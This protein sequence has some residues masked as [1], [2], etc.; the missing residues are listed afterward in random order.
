MCGI[1]GFFNNSLVNNEKIYI[2]SMSESLKHRGPDDF[3]FYKDVMITMG[4]NRFS[5]TDIPNGRQPFKSRNG[6]VI[7]FFNGE[8]YNHADLR[9][10]LRAKGYIF[11]T[12]CDGEVIPHLY[13]EYGYDFLEYLD[14]MFSICLW[15]QHKKELVLAVDPFGIKQLYFYHQDNEFSFSSEIKGLAT[16]P[17]V[18]LEIDTQALY[19]YLYYKAIFPPKTFFKQINKLEPSNFLVIRPDSVQKRQYNSKVGK[20]I[21]EYPDD[22]LQLIEI[23]EEKIIKNTVMMVPDEVNFGCLLS[24]GLDSSIITSI[25]SKYTDRKFDV[26]S[27]GYPGNLVADEREYGRRLTKDLGINLHEVILSPNEI[28]TLL[29]SVNESIE[30]PIQDPITLPTYK[31]IQQASFSNKVLFTGDGSDELFGGYAR[32]KS[33]IKD[34]KKEY[35]NQLG[36]CNFNEFNQIF[37]LENIP[38]NSFYNKFVE[39]DSL[40]QLMDLEQKT[41]LPGYHLLRLDKLSMAHTVEAR[42]PFLRGEILEIARKLLKTESCIKNNNE[43]WM[44][45]RAVSKIVPDYIINRQK[46]PFTLP[47]NE[48]IKNELFEFVESTLLASNSFTQTIIPKK[49]MQ[50]I[51]MQHKAG[52]KDHSHFIW[53]IVVLNSFVESFKTV[54]SNKNKQLIY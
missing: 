15:D 50:E 47:I 1:F 21:Y 24:G 30:E 12:Q 43:K 17:F 6:Q 48:W 34:G 18:N 46:K 14:G 11:N 20:E 10:K 29:Q 8:I 51:I 5:I 53:A 44:L 27:I 2:K 13:E 37:K 23:L 4:A 32:Y 52:I 25:L 36:I 39:L 31:V 38:Q 19:E 42:V 3:Q 16:L 26:F 22:T 35:F 9:S 28:P 54:K 41:R 49:Q 40:E 7:C 45:K 33:F